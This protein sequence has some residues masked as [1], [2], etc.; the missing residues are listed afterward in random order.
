MRGHTAII[1][2]RMQRRAPRIV[3]VNDYPCKTDWFE[4]AE[5]ATVCTH[6]DTLSNLDLRF[7]VGLRVSISATTEARAQA[8]FERVKAAG[9]QAVA[10]VHVQP[11]CHPL[12]QRGWCQVFTK[13]AAC[14]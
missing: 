9:A 1:E 4:H 7:L 12:D 6:G 5:Q 2:Q 3:F 14:A 8:L 11:N 10:A 13:E